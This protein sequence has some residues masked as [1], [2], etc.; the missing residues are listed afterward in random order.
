MQVSTANLWSLTL[1]FSVAQHPFVI[2]FSDYPKNDHQH[3]SQS[4]STSFS[5][6]ALQEPRSLGT[7]QQGLGVVT[8]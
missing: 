2:L 4:L 8:A 1:T 7:D 5:A 6:D 3:P